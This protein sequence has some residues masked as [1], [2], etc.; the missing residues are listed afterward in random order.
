MKQVAAALNLHPET[1][2]ALARSRAFPRAVMRGRGSP[3][4]IPWADVEACLARTRPSAD[5]ATAREVAAALSLHTSTV[6]A[7]VAAGVFPNAYRAESGRTSRV[8]IPWGDIE[9]F[10]KNQPR[11]NA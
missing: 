6:A 2:R 1:V 4:A 5:D 7:L 8:R 3:I 10:R 9:N 11:L